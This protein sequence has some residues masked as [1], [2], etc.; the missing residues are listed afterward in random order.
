MDALLELL[1]E[2]KEEMIETLRRMVEYESPSTDKSAVNRCVEYVAGEAEALGGRITRHRNRDYGD[3]LEAEF[4]P[5]GRSS[6]RGRLLLLGHLDTVWDLGTLERMPF[7]VARGRAWGPGVL[8]MK[9]GVT[10]ALFALRALARLRRPLPRP[11]TLLLNSDEEVGSVSSRTLTERLA[12]NC[13]AVLVLEPGTGLHGALKTARKGVGEYLVR[14]RGRASHAGVDFSKGVSATL[15]LARQIQRI[16]GFT[17]LRQGITVNAGV[18]GGGTRSNVVA[19]EAWARVDVRIA[20]R[21]D[22]AYLEKQFRSLRPFHPQARLEVT[23]GLNRP[24]ME[25]SPAIVALF[26]RARELALPLGLKL[27][28]SSTGGGSDGNFT[29]ALGV[30]TL[31]GLGG[32]GEGAHAA[33][34]SIVLSGWPLRTALLARLLTELN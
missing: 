9:S 20:R 17:R 29:A 24:P 28:E 18:I 15:E 6:T 31:D 11:V 14:V 23:G 3:H 26:R 12:R 27:E 22:E 21:A 1:R 10:A 8:D 7:R 33:N 25:R 2:H 16:A 4:G 5:R 32:A 19:E 30:P 34:E 13:R